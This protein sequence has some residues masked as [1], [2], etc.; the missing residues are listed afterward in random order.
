MTRTLPQCPWLIVQG[1][2]DELV[3]PNDIQQWA[4][5]LPESPR[6][7]MLSGV[8]HFF[9]GRLNELRQV[10]VQWLIELAQLGAEPVQSRS[11]QCCWGS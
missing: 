7:T 2:R 5:A 9:H 1:D 8:E 4:Q 11:T 3:D 6:L 10:T